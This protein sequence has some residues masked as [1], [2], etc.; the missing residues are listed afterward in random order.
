MDKLISEL[1]P[2][3]NE[4][5]LQLFNQMPDG[6]AVFELIS[7]NQ[8]DPE[9]YRF[10]EVNPAFERITGLKAE[11]VAGRT[12]L[13]VLSQSEA[14]F[15]VEYGKVILIG[16]SIHYEYFSNQLHRYFEV[17]AFLTAPNQFACSFSDIT[18]RK[19]IEEA[20]EKRVIA[21]TQPLDSPE[22]IA[23]EDLFSLE[24]IQR[25]QDE[26]SDATGVAS[27]ITHTD[28]TPITAPS[29]FCRLCS[30]IIRKTEIG[31]ANCLRS[32][33]LLGKASVDGP[34]IQPC[35]SGGLWD[36]GAG[37]SVGG[38]HVANWLIGQ[39]RDET[40]TEEKMRDYA[41]KIGAD[42]DAVV[43]AFLEVPAMSL[44]QFEKIARVLFT[45]AN[46]LSAF[47]FQ[48][49]QQAGFIRE[50]KLADDALRKNESFL[51]DIIEQT[52][53]SMWISDAK[54]TLLRL[55][56]ACREMLQIT[57]EEV[58]GKYNIL[59]DSIVQ[60]Q[61]FL[62]LVKKVFEDNESVRFIL[63]YES[64]Q[65]R[66]LPLEGKAERLLDVT[67]FPINDSL[68]NLTNAVIQHVDITA[69]YRLEESLHLTNHVFEASIGANSISDI[70][71][72]I[73]K[74][75]AAFLEMWGF[76][77]EDEITGRPIID[78]LQNPE[79]GIEII[80]ALNNIGKWEGDY[81][82]KRKN[83]ST[84]IAH[85][86]ATVVRNAEGDLI[87]Y[88]S[89]VLDITERKQAELALAAEKEQLAVTLR[90][91]GDGVITTDTNGKI[92]MLNQAAEKLTGWNSGEAYGRPL[93]DV[94]RI[95][96]ELTRKKCENPVEKVLLTGEIV[97]L[98]NHTCLIAKDGREIVVADSGAP[99]R[100]NEG[101]IIG[102]VLVFRDMTEKQ[103]LINII[104]KSQKLE[105]LG[106]LAGGIAHDFNNILGGVFGYIEMAL[107]LTSQP[108]VS[109]YLA[110]SLSSVERA[111]AL[112]Q[113]L[114][115]FARGG[116]PIKKIEELFPFVE[117]TVNF[118]L[119]GSSVSSRFKIQENLW[120][121]NFDKNQ[122]G[123]VIDNLT[124]NAQQAMPNGG[125]IDFYARNV[126]LES[127]EHVSLTD[128]NYVKLSIE[129]HGIGIPN[130][131][132][133]HIFDPYF[134]TKQKG[135]GLGLSTC[136]SI[137]HRHGGCLDVESELGIGSTFHLYLPASSESESITARKSTFHHKGS[138]TLLVMDDEEAI[139]EVFRSMLESYGYT[140]VLTDNGK[141]AIE[142]FRAE[143][144]AN[145][146]LAGMIFDLTIPGS[147][148]GKEAIGEI[149]K[150]CSTTPAFVASGYSQ[151]P[152]MANPNKYGFTASLCKPFRIAE[153]SE[154]LEKHMP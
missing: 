136:Y 63:H 74:V 61:G 152:I 119:S 127:N 29:N 60:D 125:T 56:Q 121:C 39:V 89:A 71:G 137:I 72:I 99:I 64:L 21:L 25:L 16:E 122:I 144:K 75:N 53:Y 40:Q 143:M 104:Q 31:C 54:G 148:G 66:D 106:I 135:H 151:D 1:D 81:T 20:L 131:F 24:E 67:I 41:R 78:F 128:G 79:E 34:T 96:N 103:K 26:F 58:L 8:G 110:D 6:C 19:R 45:L 15:P 69:K 50:L 129:D 35:L 43:E 126:S 98:A 142:F 7:S 120:F 3:S 77:R 28:G 153:L 68:G 30:E 139:R 114:L 18:E 44:L 105:S 90:S 147:I 55:N 49:A 123:Q 112:T 85:A 132:L 22:H 94:F 37:I 57:D 109:K 2:E 33:A 62:P 38:R 42:E 46:Q 12:T 23:F 86:L 150:I 88:Q 115:T 92:V 154:M 108:K 101:K 138:G 141:D 87:G 32:D 146:K 116:A 76:E 130:E 100:D 93:F 5:F 118:A 9:D 14:V 4:N 117:E 145:R 107:A 140:V 47:A 48:N 97:V 65:P 80:T 70:N 13:E 124:I 133:S 36:A 95:V 84:F 149:R 52:P 51:N 83:G 73:T 134:T 10:L 111:R 59:T 82:A 17:T 113:Q 11:S 91:I 102:V 27:I